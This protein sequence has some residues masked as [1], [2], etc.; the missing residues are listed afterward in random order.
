MSEHAHMDEVALYG[1]CITCV[2]REGT[3][4]DDITVQLDTR[5]VL[6]RDG[7]RSARDAAIARVDVSADDAWKAAA[8]RTI[9]A[10]AL[11]RRE[12]T[13]DA[14]WELGL[15]KPREARALGPI[16]RWAE[17]ERL[18]EATDRVQETAQVNCHAR[19][20]RVWRSLVF[21]N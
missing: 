12:F 17:S 8:R 19:P 20:I 21:T 6:D 15:P 4:R 14:V 18:I 10:L 3:G 2:V 11:S 13:S 9:E 1:Q 7:S 5:S 16:M